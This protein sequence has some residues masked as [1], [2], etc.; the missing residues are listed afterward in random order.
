MFKKTH[1]IVLGLLMFVLFYVLANKNSIV[2][3]HLTSDSD[4]NKDTPELK[5][6]PAPT[7]EGQAE[8]IADLK[9]QVTKLKEDLKAMKDQSKE[10]MAQASAAQASLQ[11]IQ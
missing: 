1:W 9:K 8:Q 4:K 3:E 7:L 10:Q 11:A 5:S 6:T 2:M